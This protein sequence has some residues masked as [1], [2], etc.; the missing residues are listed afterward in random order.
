MFK[1]P[2]KAFK[3]KNTSRISRALKEKCQEP[4][5]VSRSS[6]SNSTRFTVRA[7]RTSMNGLMARSVSHK[8]GTLIFNAFYLRGQRAV[9]AGR[10]LRPSVG[11]FSAAGRRFFYGLPV[12]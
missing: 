7:G 3:S 9:K 2:S 11:L 6:S 4:S 5:R 1:Q 12:R 8:N 10:Q